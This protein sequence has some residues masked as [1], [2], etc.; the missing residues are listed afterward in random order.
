[1]LKNHLTGLLLDTLGHSPTPGQQKL[2]EALATFVTGSGQNSLM[3]IKGYAGTGKT[4]LVSTLVNVLD[5]L[6]RKTVLL[7][8][9]GRAAKVLSAYSGK[10]AFTIHKRIYRQKSSA[11]TFGVFV[12]EKNLFTNTLFLVDEAS[13]ISNQTGENNVFGSGHLLDD[14]IHYIQN[15]KNCS[16]IIIGD[17]AQLPPVGTSIS[18]ALDKTVL[19]RYF[20]ETEVM[21]ITDVVRQAQHSGIL[22]N[23]TLIRNNII[24][25]KPEIPKLVIQGFHD[26]HFIN[27][28]DLIEC[29]N[30]TYDR[31]GI[32]NSIIICRS[33]KRANKFNEGIRKQIFGREEEITAGDLLMVVRNNYY[34][35]SGSDKIDFIANGDIIK[36]LKIRKIQEIYGYRFADVLIEFI[37]YDLKIETKIILDTLTVDSAAMRQEDNQKLFYAIMEDYQDLQ[38]K[39][40][41]YEKVKSNAFFNAL[42][43]KFAYAVTCHKAQG[44]Q[45]KNVYVD[46][47]Y[48]RTENAD[49]DFLRWIY[50]AFTRAT[51]NLY[52]VN[53]PETML[54]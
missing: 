45:W 22:M 16:L 17:T 41:Q 24:A 37:D 18:P 11:D 43:V 8:P 34:W 1:M 7:A 13:M 12:L 28:N 47:G 49:I 25:N 38:P 10:N 9:T 46:F 39:K 35:L 48:F 20:H 4:T 23:A 26:V 40:S 31:D 42:Q 15:E 5:S 33:N 51:E 19:Q 44:G 14:L 54:G 21:E 29:L 2:I 36:V 6:G 30:R 52:L 27:S 32:E 53:F 3:I 50:T